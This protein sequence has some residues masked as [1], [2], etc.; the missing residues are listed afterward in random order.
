MH[1][2]YYVDFADR[3]R[4]VGLNLLDMTLGLDVDKVVSDLI[5]LGEAL[6]SKYWGPRM[7]AVWRYATRTLALINVRRVAMGLPERQYTILDVPPLLLAPRDRREPFLLSNLP[8]DTPEGQDV[9]WWWSRWYEPLRS[10]LQQDVISPVLT[11][12]FRL[13]GNSSSRSVFGQAVSTL[14][15]RQV[16]RQGGI[17]LVHTATGELGEEIGGFMGAVILNLL[18]VV[19]R[20][21][22]AQA[23]ARR[24]PCLVIVD[25]F[26]SIPSVNYGALLSELQKFEVAFVL[27]T[28]SLARLRAI[29]RELPGIIF[30]SVATLMSFQVNHED[31]KYLSGE[32]DGVPPASLVNLEP[33]HAYVKTTGP[34]GRR[35]P[36]YS[37]RGNPPLAPDPSVAARVLEQVSGYSRLA[38]GTQEQASRLAAE[39][40]D[41]AEARQREEEINTWLQAREESDFVT[42]QQLGE[43]ARMMATRSTQD[44][45]PKA[46]SIGRGMSARSEQNRRAERSRKRRPQGFRALGA[47]D[48]NDH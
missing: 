30:A 31:A 19:I 9:R 18:N 10:S 39:L 21:R 42:E 44:Y 20:E 26:Q 29:E 16:L 28:Q 40:S 25:E 27:G 33:F 11:K 35:L 1:E 34:D 6:W 24:T 7:E 4:C 36:V 14:N 13:S 2:T 32:L 43:L 5:G 15:L 22:A 17:L 38:A 46:G 8:L 48:E 37:M 3:Q 23:R 12:V 41:G 47:G 45:G